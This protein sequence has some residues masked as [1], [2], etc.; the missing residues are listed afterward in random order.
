M[1]ES[2]SA[3]HGFDSQGGRSV[4]G[5]SCK[6]IPSSSMVCKTV[7]EKHQKLTGLNPDTKL[8]YQPHNK[9]GRGG[10]KNIH[11][12]WSPTKITYRNHDEVIFSIILHR[13]YLSR[14]SPGLLSIFTIEVCPLVRT[15]DSRCISAWYLITRFEYSSEYCVT[16][17]WIRL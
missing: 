1:V 5:F 2:A 16:F 12:L 15:N 9:E 4:T 10:E 13:Y 6:E 17:Q 7:M 11:C 3:E 14:V 8:H